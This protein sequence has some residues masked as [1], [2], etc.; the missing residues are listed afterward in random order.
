MALHAVGRTD[1][2]KIHQVNWQTSSPRIECR[3]LF[4]IWS[5]KLEICES[6]EANQRDVVIKSSAKV[7]DE[8]TC[9]HRYAG[10]QCVYFFVSSV[11]S[12]VVVTGVTCR[13]L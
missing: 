10:L 3:S 12:A 4:G 2:R 1:F 8:T 7:F 6:N 5:F 9:D 11:V 13:S